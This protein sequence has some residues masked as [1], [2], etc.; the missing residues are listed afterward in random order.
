MLNS[1]LIFL[2]VHLAQAI[3]LT[4]AKL[5]IK[6]SI[7]TIVP[8]VTTVLPSAIP[9][10]E[11]I[12]DDFRKTVQEKVQEKINEAKSILGVK[13]AWQGVVKQA[14]LLEVELEVD[15]KTQ[16]IDLSDETVFTSGTRKLEL[17][18][19]KSGQTILALGYLKGETLEA[20]RLVLV[21]TKPEVSYLT[22]I[23]Q[24][25]DISKSTKT[26]LVI[27][28]QNKGKEVQVIFDTK[29]QVF[30]MAKKLIDYKDLE[31]SQKVISITYP[32]DKT[33]KIQIAT[34]IYVLSPII[35]KTTPTPTPKVAKPT[36]TQ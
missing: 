2:S 8:T 11:N 12:V 22:T 27:P 5:P 28:T 21:E 25:A 1:N 6:T 16:K 32:K 29:S 18:T 31:K 23:G 10:K 17:A 4:P 7:T 13:T 20:K 24:I 9:T 36:N 15:G 19:I 35:P 34:K 26:I 30:N 14:T 3:T 33:G